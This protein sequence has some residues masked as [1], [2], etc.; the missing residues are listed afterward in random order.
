[1]VFCSTR[2]KY[3]FAGDTNQGRSFS[4]RMNDRLNCKYKNIS[5][6]QKL[7]FP[8]FCIGI[9]NCD[10]VTDKAKSDFVQKF[11][12]RY[13]NEENFRFCLRG[14]RIV[15]LEDEFLGILDYEELKKLMKK[16]HLSEDLDEEKIFMLMYYSFNPISCSYMDTTRW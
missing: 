10:K 13:M 6:Y 5:L 14:R 2:Y 1:M 15:F 11:V 3:R 7:T 8:Y 16:M 4:Q 12:D 9:L